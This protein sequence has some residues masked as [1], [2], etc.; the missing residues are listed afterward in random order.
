MAV[1]IKSSGVRGV[2][3]T[4]KVNERVEMNSS[5]SMILSSNDT[6][7]W[8]LRQKVA[9]DPWVKAATLRVGDECILRAEM[10]S[11]HCKQ[12]SNNVICPVNG[13]GKTPR[14]YKR[15]FPQLLRPNEVMDSTPPPTQPHCSECRSSGDAETSERL[16]GLKVTLDDLLDAVVA[17]G[18]KVGAEG[19]YDEEAE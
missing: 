6:L 14:L 2:E 12:D 3:S 18:L 9:D 11:G 8:N 16:A 5:I 17:I 13:N 15:S 7:S 10:K 1:H 19:F 4:T